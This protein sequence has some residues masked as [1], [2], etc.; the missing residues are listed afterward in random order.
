M[1]HVHV[2][3]GSIPEASTSATREATE[4]PPTAGTD[5]VVVVVAVMGKV[6]VCDAA[7]AV[8][9]GVGVGVGS[10]T[11][12]G[13][14]AVVDVVGTTAGADVGAATTVTWTR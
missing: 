5:E 11:V 1:L 13:G 2:G 8:G 10:T 4:A 14:T 3:P 6:T 7:T 9:V 12:V